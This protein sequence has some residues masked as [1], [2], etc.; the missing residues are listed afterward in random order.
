MIYLE[1][2]KEQ[3]GHGIATMELTFLC[4]KFKNKIN[5][6]SAK[7]YKK[8]KAWGQARRSLLHKEFKAKVFE[9]WYLNRILKNEN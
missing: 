9:G 8:S 1:Y 4:R 6:L 2:D 3:E 5:S 7:W